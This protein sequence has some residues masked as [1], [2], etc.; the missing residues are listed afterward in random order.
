MIAFLKGLIESKHPEAVQIDVR[1]VGYEVGISTN[2]FEQLPSV[3]EEVKLLVYH[4]ITD[5][6]QRL[7]G[8]YKQ[9]EKNLFEL[10]ITVKNVG[11]KLGLAILSGMPAD[12]TIEA[13]VQQDIGALSN[14]SGIGKK[15]AQR[16]VLELKDKMGEIS[17]S[18]ISDTPVHTSSEI[19]QE[20]VSALE[21]LGYNKKHSEQ[22][23][24]KALKSMDG[25]ASVTNLVKAALSALNR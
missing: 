18:E 3:G 20:A 11:P 19:Q 22:A 13:I 8:F 24:S 23:V 17:P 12:Q 2:T 15:T 7:F 25:D 9:D 1:G 21:S 5:N 10:L 16:M 6:D 4:H 14:I